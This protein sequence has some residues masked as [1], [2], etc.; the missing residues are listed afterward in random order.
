MSIPNRHQANLLFREAETLNPGGWIA[1]SSLVSQAAE[2]I[3]S[4]IP[5]LDPQAAG[6]LGLLHDIGR[7]VG[8]TDFEKRLGDVTLRRGM[9]AATVD[10]WKATLQLKANFEARLGKSIYVLLPGIV[11]NTFT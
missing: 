8:V 4:H 11:E 2:I 5:D 6:I 7:R 3:A 9:N 10:K 1:H